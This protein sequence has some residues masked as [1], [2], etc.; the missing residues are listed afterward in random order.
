M[1]DAIYA[2]KIKH[3]LF[4]PEEC[5]Q[6]I[7]L[8]YGWQD[9]MVSSAGE[10]DVVNPTGKIGRY[11]LLPLEDSTQWIYERLSKFLKASGGFG[12]VVETIGAPLKV[13]MY[14][15]G[16]F[17]AWHS[18]I[19]NPKNVDRKIAISVQLCDGADYDGGALQFFDHPDPVSAP[20]DQGCAVAYPAFLPH[21]VAKVT[22]GTRYALT[23]WCLG[24]PFK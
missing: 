13:Q 8:D 9:S 2:A 22:R 14:P 5:A 21:Q 18:D 10:E 19:G 16:G 1:A 12:F 17:H 6:L 15:R 11:M 7:A 3:K 4:T 24:P 20:R 23:A